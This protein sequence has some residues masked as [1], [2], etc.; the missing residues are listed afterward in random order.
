MQTHR[1]LTPCCLAIAARS[2]DDG[3]PQGAPGD[4]DNAKLMAWLKA[5]LKRP[6]LR[7]DVMLNYNH[8]YTYMEKIGFSVAVDGAKNLTKGLPAFAFC[9]L[10]PPGVF[11]KNDVTEDVFL[12]TKL[13]RTSTSEA[14]SSR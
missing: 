2:C 5:N 6:D 3:E 4:S 9:S 1:Q 12:T 7:N 14:P 10:N 13:L 8:S 11:Y